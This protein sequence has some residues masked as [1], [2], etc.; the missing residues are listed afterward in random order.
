MCNVAAS[1][2]RANVLNDLASAYAAGRPRSDLFCEAILQ[3]VARKDGP[4]CLLDIGCGAGLDG[5]ADNQRRIRSRAAQ[6]IGVEPDPGIEV[7]DAFDEVHRTRFEDA[8][9]APASVHV[10]YSTFVLEHIVDPDGFWRKLNDVLVP[11]GDFLAITVDGRHFFRHLSQSLQATRLK[12]LYLSALRGRSGETR[13]VNY[14][15]TYRCN[16]PR[17][18][19]A[20]AGRYGRVTSQSIHRLG[21]LDFYVPRQLRWLMHAFDRLAMQGWTPGSILLVHFV[22]NDIVQGSG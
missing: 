10:A 14:P 3:L 9:I 17:Q 15:T 21:Q 2:V 13:Y 1:P 8:A 4:C 22:K 20:A 12:D 19:A 16:T 7:S 5:N 6:C 11:G 18:L